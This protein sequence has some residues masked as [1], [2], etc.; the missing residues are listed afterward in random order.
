[1]PVKTLETIA[2]EF[3]DADN[4][5]PELQPKSIPV[6]RS[7]RLVESQI[8]QTRT[9]TFF[10]GAVTA[11]SLSVEET[12]HLLELLGRTAAKVPWQPLVGRD[13]TDRELTL[14]RA[15]SSITFRWWVEVPPGW[16][17]I[18]AVFDYVKAIDDRQRAAGDLA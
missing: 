18:G 11:Y 3:A 1:M 17:S 7:L 12:E 8:N 6:T 9:F 14:K 15:M 13:G 10:E 16:E 4:S 5:P 2:I